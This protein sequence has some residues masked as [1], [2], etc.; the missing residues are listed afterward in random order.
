MAV[1]RPVYLNS[2]NIQEMD[3]TMFG[4][5]KNVFRYQLGRA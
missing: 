1:R 5:L 4:A 3:D 2:G